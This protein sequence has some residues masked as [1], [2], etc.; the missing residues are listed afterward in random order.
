[1]RPSLEALGELSPAVAI[2]VVTVGVAVIGWLDYVTGVEIRLVPFYYLPLSMA[3][4][5]LGRRGAIVTAII[6]G[7]MWMESNYVAGR[8]YSTDGIA[9]LNFFLQSTSFV[10]V[11]LLI[12]TIRQ[13]YQQAEELSRTD[14]LT[15][16]LN[17]RA[18][19]DEAGRVLAIARRH[20][21][22]VTLAY[23]DLDNFKAVNDTLGHDKGDDLLR[24]TADM[25]RKTLRG[26]DVIARIGGDE[27]VVL[28][29][30]TGPAGAQPLLER[31]RASLLKSLSSDR[32]QRSA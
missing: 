4:W 32:H 27:F 13:S 22:E 11:G 3:A 15:R 12:A 31:L 2:A 23:I 19:K 20:K 21:H 10:I 29:P 8:H 17:A 30:E 6:C 26:G 25:L 7:A 9:L 1:M 14:S 5:K 24:A 16:L 28:L 18:F